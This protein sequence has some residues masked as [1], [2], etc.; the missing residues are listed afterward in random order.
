M[1]SGIQNLWSVMDLKIY[2]NGLKLKKMSFF[3]LL[4][5]IHFLLFHPSLFSLLCHPGSSSCLLRLAIVFVAS[6]TTSSIFSS[7]HSF[8]VL[9]SSAIFPLMM[10]L[11]RLQGHALLMHRLAGPRPWFIGLFI[12]YR[13]KFPFFSDHDL[14]PGPSVNK[15]NNLSIALRRAGKKMSFVEL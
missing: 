3:S 5:L 15:T 8:D 4:L 7:S 14:N 6:P 10:L 1:L 9:P 13:G 11:Q 2:S 12:F